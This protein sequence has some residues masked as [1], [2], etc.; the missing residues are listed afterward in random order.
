MLKRTFIA[1]VFTI[2]ERLKNEI[3]L[4]RKNIKGVNVKWVETHNLHLTLAF[5]G[6]ITP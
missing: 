2:S 1:Q 4:I 5:L 3:E 6:E